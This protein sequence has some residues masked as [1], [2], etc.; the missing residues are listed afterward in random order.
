MSVVPTMV[1]DGAVRDVPHADPVETAMPAPGYVVGPVGPVG[2][3]LPAPPALPVGPVG[4]GVVDTAPVGPVGPGVVETAPVGP[5]GPCDPVG[6][7][8]PFTSA[9][10][11]N[12]VFGNPV[13]PVPPEE[14]SVTG[15]VQ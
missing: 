3:V 8:T 6:P 2:P 4:P 9:K 11:K 5:V 7:V 12:W 1:P 13:V 14:I 15:Y 10:N